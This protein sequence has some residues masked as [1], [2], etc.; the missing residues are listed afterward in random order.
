MKEKNQN[1]ENLVDWLNRMMGLVEDTKEQDSTNQT[2][3]TQTSQIEATPI[4]G[5]ITFLNGESAKKAQQHFQQ[6]KEE[7]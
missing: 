6:N 2:T 1:Q 3:P 5:R 4:S 7:K